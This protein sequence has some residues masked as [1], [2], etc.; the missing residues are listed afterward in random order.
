MIKGSLESMR[1]SLNLMAQS[2]SE[3]RHNLTVLADGMQKLFDNTHY[4][5]T[6]H[7]SVPK[8]LEGLL[9]PHYELVSFWGANEQLNPFRLRMLLNTLCD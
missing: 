2:A 9:E 6:D 1:K 5:S 3:T 4:S 7:I 8:A